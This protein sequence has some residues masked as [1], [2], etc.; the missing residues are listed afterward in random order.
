MGKEAAANVDLSSSP[1][2]P[3]L[4]SENNGTLQHC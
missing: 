4:E 1:P 3:N 2:L